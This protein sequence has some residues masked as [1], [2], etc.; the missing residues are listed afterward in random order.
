MILR[1]LLRSM[2]RQPVDAWDLTH[3]KCAVTATRSLYAT[4]QSKK[5]PNFARFQRGAAIGGWRATSL[6]ETLARALGTALL[7]GMVSYVSIDADVFSDASK[8]DI[9][10]GA[11]A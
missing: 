4:I 11:Q 2:R 9:W 10:S 1:K 5:A 7:A 6:T 8:R 3:M